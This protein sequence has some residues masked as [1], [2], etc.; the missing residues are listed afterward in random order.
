MKCVPKESRFPLELLL[1][2]FFTW[3]TLIHK[4]K[5]KIN[6]MDLVLSLLIAGPNVK[7]FLGVLNFNNENFFLTIGPL[8][9]LNARS[10]EQLHH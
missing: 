1:S 7:L 4:K 5:S 6:P 2:I 10:T 9:L 8:E 3:S